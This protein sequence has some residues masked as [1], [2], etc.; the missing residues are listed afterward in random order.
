MLTDRQIK[1]LPT[2]G[3]PYR[4]REKSTDP[5]LKGFG[6]QVS[7]AG[8]KSFF[9][10]YTFNGKRG[11]FFKVGTYP[12]MTL[13]EARETCRETRK[14][15]EQGIDPK[16]EL[17]RRRI[18]EEAER[19]NQERQQRVERSIGRY[20]D[21]VRVYLA[22]VDNMTT[23]QEIGRFLEKDAKPELQKRR[24]TD[25][26]PKDI[27][28]VLNRAKQRGAKRVPWMLHSYLHAAFQYAIANQELDGVL[29]PL[30]RN[31][32]ASVKK[33]DDGITPGERDLSAKEIKLLWEALD[34]DADRM[35]PFTIAAIRLALLSGQ[36]LQEVLR[37]RWSQVDLSER[38][39]LFPRNQTKT[40]RSHLLPT[41]DRMEAAFHTVPQLG[42]MVFPNTRQPGEPMP[43]RTI[44]R[45]IDRLCVRHHIEPFTPRD[46]R[47]TCTT[48][49][50]RI[51][52]QPSVRFQLQNRT[53]GDIESKHY[54][55][56][57][58]LPEKRTALETWEGELDR[59]L[60]IGSQSNIAML[61]RSP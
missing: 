40:K 30:D 20:E 60:G 45:A 5:G 47:R 17:E 41:T 16:A 12:A 49:W 31:P 53:L 48:H 4:K 51:G 57:D 6:I 35:S 27:R 52:I 43:F 24:V 7:S 11:H 34:N 36:R 56:Y 8:A 3:K 50:A 21:L 58:G 2:T 25:I 26:E 1:T 15:I 32:V 61:T 28:R 55:R 46:L 54:N 10:E 29:F 13:V 18:A 37:T 9:V 22:S 19:K 38:T 42:E 14:R 39:W 23:R 59:I 44:T 33:P